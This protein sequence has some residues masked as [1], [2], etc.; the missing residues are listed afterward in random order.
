MLFE[1]AKPVIQNF[2]QLNV[3]EKMCAVLSNHDLVKITAKILSRNVHSRTINL[4]LYV[5]TCV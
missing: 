1:R 3:E 4:T 2:D 5:H